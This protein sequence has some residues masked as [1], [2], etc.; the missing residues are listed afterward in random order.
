[1]DSS[2]LNGLY[3]SLYEYLNTYLLHNQKEPELKDKTLEILKNILKHIE[4]YELRKR[5]DIY[6]ENDK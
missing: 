3:K 1:M 4:P 2:E 6:K 5:Q